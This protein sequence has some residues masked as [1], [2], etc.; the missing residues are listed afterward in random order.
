M[1][2]RQIQIILSDLI[3][4]I[5]KILNVSLQVLILCLFFP[6]FD[7]HFRKLPL[8]GKS[9]FRSNF[10]WGAVQRQ[11]GAFRRAKIVMLEVDFKRHQLLWPGVS[12]SMLC[13]FRGVFMHREGVSSQ[14]FR[15]SLM[16]KYYCKAVY[17]SPTMFFFFLK[18]TCLLCTYFAFGSLYQS[19]ILITSSKKRKRSKMGVV[20]KAKNKL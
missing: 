7:W 3:C 1:D 11:R 5:N 20:A 8:C 2:I 14:I 17:I 9:H 19:R 16:L 18:L 15:N 13:S 4:A 12:G 6:R 10:R